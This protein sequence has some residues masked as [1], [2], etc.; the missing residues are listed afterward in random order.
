[1]IKYRF[2]VWY[3]TKNAKAVSDF[4]DKCDLGIVNVCLKEIIQ[5]NYTKEEK[6]ISYFKHLI[7]TAYE[8]YECTVLD[9]RGGKME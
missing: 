5:F 8:S 9:I 2:E 1:M 6:P 3:Q 4:L 7:Q